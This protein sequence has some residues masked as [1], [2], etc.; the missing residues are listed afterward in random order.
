MKV[1]QKLAMKFL[2]KWRS[3][4]SLK[5][6]LNWKVGGDAINE[7]DNI[8]ILIRYTHE[9]LVNNNSSTHL[10]I[11]TIL[12]LSWRRQKLLITINEIIMYDIR[13]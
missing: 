3:N 7:L 1:E 13:I 5:I 6:I 12:L 10:M 9:N 8:F 2:G 4:G 11:V